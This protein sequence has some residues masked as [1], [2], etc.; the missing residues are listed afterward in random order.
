MKK[1]FLQIGMSLPY[2]FLAMGCDTMWD[3][4]LP[5]PAVV[6]CV[7]LLV[8]AAKKQGMVRCWWICSLIGM[9]LSVGLSACVTAERWR[10]YFKPFSAQT[11][12]VIIS[13][14]TLGAQWIAAK[15]AC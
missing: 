9:G 4:F 2:A 6:L 1:R 3:T 13:L 15:K 14:L 10:W 5:Y 8:R 7:V 12:A 11:M